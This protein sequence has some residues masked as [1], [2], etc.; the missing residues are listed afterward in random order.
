MQFVH[1]GKGIAIN[2]ERHTVALHDYCRDKAAPVGSSLY[3]SLLFLD[4]P[5]RQAITAVYAFQQEVGDI[6]RNC[7]NIE[8]AHAKLAWWR[9]EIGELFEQRPH[10]PVTQSIAEALRYFPIAQAQLIEVVDGYEMDLQQGYYADFKSLQLYCYHVSSAI[11]LVVSEILGY[12]N[13]QTAKFAQ[14]MGLAQQLTSIIRDIG[15][16]ARRGR[17]YLPLDELR[18]FGVSENDIFDARYSDNFKALLAFQA[19]RARK[20]Y[21]Q[22]LSML[23]NEDRKSQR[24]ALA[25]AAIQRKILDEIER[26]K[27]QVL[28]RRLSL[29]PLRKLWISARTRLE[30]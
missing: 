9:M 24:A 6:V 23:A 16:D 2:K 18:R 3:Y 8:P 10:H 30:N 19:Q 12:R 15:R 17:I 20:F 5:R 29:T 22:A 27:Y 4:K 28:D 25:M 21:D 26:D 13:R 7:V 11:S 1:C 14:E